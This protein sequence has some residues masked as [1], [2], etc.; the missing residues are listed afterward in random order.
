M[1]SSHGVKRKARAAFLSKLEKTELQENRGNPAAPVM[2][3][4]GGEL[5]VACGEG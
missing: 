3:F 1:R 2:P 5:R 4:E